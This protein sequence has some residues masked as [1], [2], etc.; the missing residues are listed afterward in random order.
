MSPPEAEQ[1]ESCFASPEEEG[2][3]D[4]MEEGDGE[5]DEMVL[6]DLSQGRQ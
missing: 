2:E 6:R 3:G 1:M 4:A 5:E